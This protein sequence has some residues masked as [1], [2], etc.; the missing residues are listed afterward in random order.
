MAELPGNIHEKIGDLRIERGLTKKQVSEDLGIPASQLT[1]IENEDIKSIG[2]ELII[3]FADY[4]GVS[5][6]YLLGRT[7][8]RSQKN[9]ELNELGLSNNALITL[10]SGKVNTELL[11]ENP[12]QKTE[13][14]NELRHLNAQKVSGTE[15]DLEKLKATFLKIMR[16]VKKE[17]GKSK[18]DV[19]AEEM[20]K[21]VKQLHQEALKHKEHMT[22]AKMAELTA[23][24]LL[25]AGMDGE[26][27]KL[28]EK[29]MENILKDSN[30][31]QKKR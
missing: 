26:N 14:T 30:K 22:E 28:F 2:H 5:T 25:P 29:L 11:K 12:S 31:K 27:L 4:F 21:Q 24:M 6:D 15:A 8:V 19:A 18:E 10:L 1:R 3:K 20:R 23:K 7:S 9:I 17:Y 13:I 16:D